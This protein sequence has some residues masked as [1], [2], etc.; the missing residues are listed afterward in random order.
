MEAFIRDFLCFRSGKFFQPNPGLVLL[1]DIEQVT[2]E[3]PKENWLMFLKD[4][5]I[6]GREILPFGKLF[7][8]LQDIFLS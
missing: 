5:I 4:I 1:A 8:M 2:S 6:Q 7:C 3:V